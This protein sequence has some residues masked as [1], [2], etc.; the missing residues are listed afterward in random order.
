MRTA[1]ELSEIFGHKNID[2]VTTLKTEINDDADCAEGESEDM[3]LNVCGFGNEAYF[4]WVT[5]FGDPIGDVFLEYDI[6]DEELPLSKFSTA[7]K[8]CG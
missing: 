5:E 7:D 8:F 6:S 1:K 3:D 4:E 2:S